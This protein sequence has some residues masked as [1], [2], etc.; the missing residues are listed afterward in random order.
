MVFDVSAKK[1]Q[2]SKIYPS[3]SIGSTSVKLEIA[4][5]NAK[6]QAGLMARKSLPPN[7]GMLFLFDKQEKPVFWMK[8]CLIPLDIIFIRKG[9]VVLIYKNLPPCKVE[10]CEYYPSVEFVDSVLEVNAGFADKHGIKINSPA[11]AFGIR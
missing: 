8:D 3:M 4:D 9:K 7:Q 6:R 5:T 10:P 2:A 11:K 1:T